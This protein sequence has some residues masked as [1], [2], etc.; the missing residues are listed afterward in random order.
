M[1]HHE[2]LECTGIRESIYSYNA[3]VEG[4]VQTVAKRLLEFSDIYLDG[5]YK[6]NDTFLEILAC[7]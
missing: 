5:D 1:K 4:F 6:V 7:R 2:I 3:D